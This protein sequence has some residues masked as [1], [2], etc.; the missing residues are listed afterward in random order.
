MSKSSDLGRDNGESCQAKRSH[1]DKGRYHAGLCWAML[2][3]CVVKSLGEISAIDTALKATGYLLETKIV[4]PHL[5]FFLTST[6][7]QSPFN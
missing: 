5:L 6:L 3:L 4:S 2:G 7:T 1:I